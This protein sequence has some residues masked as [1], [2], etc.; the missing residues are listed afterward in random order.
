MFYQIDNTESNAIIQE[1]LPLKKDGLLNQLNSKHH[2][3]Q[4]LQEIIMSN[5]QQNI[6]HQL[7]INPL[8]NITRSNTETTPP[9]Q[10]PK[11]IPQALKCLADFNN[12]GLNE[13]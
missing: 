10:I 1:R 8:N 9:L 4:Y 6:P 2:Y 11:R 7:E 5:S 3:Q 12:P 13:R